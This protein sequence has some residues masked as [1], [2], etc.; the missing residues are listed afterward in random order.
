MSIKSK[1]EI[2]KEFLKMI[3]SCLETT[4]EAELQQGYKLGREALESKISLLQVTD[5]FLDALTEALSPILKEKTPILVNT[6]E[7]F[8]TILAP[9]EMI[10]RGFQESISKLLKANETL[11]QQTKEL[12]VINKGLETFSYTASHDLK[13]PLRIISG[14]GEILLEDY[15]KKLDEKGRDYLSKMISSSRKMGQLIEGLLTLGKLG[16]VEITRSTI[17][18]SQLAM[19]IIRDLQTTDPTRHVEILIS[20]NIEAQGDKALIYSVMNNLLRNAWKYTSKSLEAKIEFGVLLK[21]DKPIYFIRDNGVGFDMQYVDK[22][23]NPFQRLHSESEFEGTGV[24][25][26]TVH[27]IIE[28]HSGSIWAESEIDQG[29]TFYFTLF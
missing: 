27:R 24:G 14:F 5:V 7:L 28:L 12:T 3:C 6:R 10:H 29:A 13:A 11:K 18:L 9:F 8:S 23:F 2:K 4:T 16:H 22:V 20:E 25:L 21:E 19:E 15:G 17:N 26:A 1:E